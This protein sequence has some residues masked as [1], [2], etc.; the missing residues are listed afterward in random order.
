[1]D[2]SLKS[3]R[4]F[5]SRIQNG[6]NVLHEA[7]RDNVRPMPNMRIRIAGKY[8]TPQDLKEVGSK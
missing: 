6:M 8:E 1:M 4:L 5:S 7:E 2:S 3:I